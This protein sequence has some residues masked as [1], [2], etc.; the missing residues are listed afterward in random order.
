MCRLIWRASVGW[1]VRGAPLEEGRPHR[2]V[3]DKVEWYGVVAVRHGQEVGVWVRGDSA[4][5]Y[6]PLY[7]G[8]GRSCCR[9]S[10]H[11]CAHRGLQC[12]HWGVMGC[13]TAY[14]VH[15]GLVRGSSRPPAPSSTR[16]RSSQA[17]QGSKAMLWRG[18]SRHCRRAH[19]S[20]GPAKSIM[21]ATW[22]QLMDTN[23]GRARSHRFANWMCHRWLSS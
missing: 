1:G 13:G 11:G 23:V 16:H 4:E 15:Q 17:A 21:V 5:V 2:Q 7:V 12:V 14:M 22:G 19:T 8:V 20:R 3:F 10:P 9:A 6:A 18:I